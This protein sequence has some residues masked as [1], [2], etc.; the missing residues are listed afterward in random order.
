MKTILRIKF[1]IEVKSDKC[2]LAYV[3]IAMKGIQSVVSEFFSLKF[4]PCNIAVNVNVP[5]LIRDKIV[6]YNSI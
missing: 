4:I 5:S 6:I 1:Y 3:I 2:L